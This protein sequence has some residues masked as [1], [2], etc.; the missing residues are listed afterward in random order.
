MECPHCS[1]LQFSSPTRISW[2]LLNLVY[3]S[4]E[5]PLQK[6]PGET[7]W[8][9]CTPCDFNTRLVL[10]LTLGIAVLPFAASLASMLCGQQTSCPHKWFEEQERDCGLQVA[11]GCMLP[12]EGGY[13]EQSH[14]KAWCPA[15]ALR[16]GG[17]NLFSRMWPRYTHDETH[18][19]SV[20]L[21]D[22]PSQIS[23]CRA[24]AC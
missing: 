5:R 4:W 2:V 21:S 11:L 20:L 19:S 10:A 3:F 6:T 12:A 24:K 1:L 16:H 13:P 17:D 8:V 9:L 23:Q 14:W 15:A 18:H 22:P 7:V